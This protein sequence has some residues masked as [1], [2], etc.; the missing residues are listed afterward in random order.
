MNSI[1][2]GGPA[3]P[4]EDSMGTATRPGMSLRQYAAIKLRVPES[5]TDW[6]DDMIRSSLRDEIAAKAMQSFLIDED[7]DSFTCGEWAKASYEMA[8]A[9]L[10]ASE[11]E[12]GAA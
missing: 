2:D 11:Q 1:S 7:R 4:H 5:G 6:L 10:K 3:F 9:M 12:G 8:D